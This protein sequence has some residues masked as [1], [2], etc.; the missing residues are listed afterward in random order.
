[1]HKRVLNYRAVKKTLFALY[2]NRKWAWSR[3]AVGWGSLIRRQLCWWSGRAGFPS[4]VCDIC[5]LQ[6]RALIISSPGSCAISA[7]SGEGGGERSSPFLAGAAVFLP[8]RV[9]P[10]SVPRAV[11]SNLWLRDLQS[12]HCNVWLVERANEPGL[13]IPSQVHCRTFV[14]RKEAEQRGWQL[15]G[16]FAIARKLPAVFPGSLVEVDSSFLGVRWFFVL[17]FFGRG[18]LQGI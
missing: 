3:P 11:I 15:H 13:S 5:V 14:R 16:I 12:W 2:G 10:P 9:P 18:L 6:E 8:S 4:L 1:M 17:V 7:F